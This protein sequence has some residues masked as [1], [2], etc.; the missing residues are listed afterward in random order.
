MSEIGMKSE[1]REIPNSLQEI[2]D[3]RSI[4]P[5]G[6]VTVKDSRNFWDKQFGC[7]ISKDNHIEKNE[8]ILSKKE[9][10][11]NTKT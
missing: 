6:D 10:K 1:T 3:Y 7:E 4:K 2:N 11:K 9:S 5:E 8:N